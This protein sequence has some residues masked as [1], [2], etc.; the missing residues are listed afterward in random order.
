MK[1]YFTILFATLTLHGFSQSV[2]YPAADSKAYE[3][4]KRENKIPQ[5]LNL[6]NPKIFTPSLEDLKRLGGVH[7]MTAS[8][9]CNC[10]IPPD[11]TYTV[12]MAPNDDLS[13]NSLSIPFTFCLY[14][15]NYNSLYI[16]NNGNI[17][18][19]QAYSTFSSSPFPD[20][21]YIMVAPFW[22]DVDTQGAGVV[23][24][25]ITPTAMYVNWVGV[26]Y[27]PAQTDKVNTFQLI[28]TDGTDPILPTGNNIAFCYGD[29]QW[30]TGSASQG[31]NGFGGIPAT[32]GVNQ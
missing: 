26:G 4:M 9:T 16:N 17:S 5:N 32:V 27:Y 23:E 18:F 7:P 29:M 12:A 3:Q 6:A 24:Y 22:G 11:G 19:G 10:Y 28:I 14:G 1:K 2:N 25:K 31:V 30:T 20:P 8:I 15:N 13:T 21:S